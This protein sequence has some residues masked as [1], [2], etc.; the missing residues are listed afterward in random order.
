[1]AL[2]RHITDRPLAIL[3]TV[4][5]AYVSYVAA[6]HAH[7]SGILATV[8]A[9]LYLG[10]N[11]HRAFADADTR[12]SGIAFWEVL[13]FT[14]NAL[15]FILLGLQFPALTR[16]V[17]EGELV[18]SGLLIAGT[19]IGI[20]MLA[21]FV[22]GVDTADGWRERIVVGYTGMRGAVSLAAALSVDL[23]AQGRSDIIFLSVVVIGVTLVGQG[24]TLPLLMRALGV[25]AARVW[26]PEE[27]IA[28]LEAA[29][30]ALDRIDDL[31]DEFDDGLP[32]SVKRLRDLYRARF[33]M[34]QDV[35]SGDR[36]ARH[37]V[38]D[39]RTGYGTLRRE[40]IGVERDALLGLRNEGRL[41][42]E[43]LRLIQRDLDLE[44][45]RLTPA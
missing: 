36:D 3:M 27:A 19:V 14:L 41:R 17:A 29:Q 38:R 40:L 43:V 45:A 4:L 16:E 32:E 31:E 35:L 28:R 21:Q 39:V 8:M 22:P 1:V 42:P 6:E 23:D 33:R 13:E 9:G 10:W 5:F 2:L 24:L 37:H 26:S 44:E 18:L 30:A 12:L 34:C 7:A 20:R 11:S 15:V 25:S